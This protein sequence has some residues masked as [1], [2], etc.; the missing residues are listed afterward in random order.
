MGSGYTSTRSAA[1]EVM[2]RAGR[3]R[4][5]RAAALAVDGFRLSGDEDL[6]VI[7]AQRALLDVMMTARQGIGNQVEALVEAGLTRV[8]G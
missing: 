8:S 1:I 3:I 7:D 5:D 4:I 2:H 6:S